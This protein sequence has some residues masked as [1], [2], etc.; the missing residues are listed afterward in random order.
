MRG[1]GVKDGEMGRK[2]GKMF[3]LWNIFSGSQ[4]LQ[5]YIFAVLLRQKLFVVNLRYLGYLC[6]LLF[7]CTHTK[8]NILVY[9]DFVTVH[10]VQ[11]KLQINK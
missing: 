10:V 2:E 6:N 5:F 3:A 4:R 1:K 11:S 9:F 7:T 8:S